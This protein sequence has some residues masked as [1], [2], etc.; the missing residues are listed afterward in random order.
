MARTYGG[1]FIEVRKAT[2]ASILRKSR[3]GLRLPPAAYA[4]LSPQP[5]ITLRYHG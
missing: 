3:H 2:L 1:S 4:E 5:A